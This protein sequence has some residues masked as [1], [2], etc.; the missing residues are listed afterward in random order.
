MLL[1]FLPEEQ[2]WLNSPEI[3]QKKDGT[4]YWL[5]KEADTLNMLLLLQVCYIQQF[6]VPPL[7]VRREDSARCL[8]A[9]SHT[10]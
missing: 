1:L 4:I 2:G 8:P 3:C 9:G 10:V 7:S 5:N 6:T